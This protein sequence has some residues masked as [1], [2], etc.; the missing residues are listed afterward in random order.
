MSQT[1]IRP[2]TPTERLALIG[3]AVVVAATVVIGALA[4]SSH[5]SPNVTVAD[6]PT[7]T[8]WSDGCQVCSR[9]PEGIACSLP[10]IACVP[11][12]E[13]CLVRNDG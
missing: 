1:P 11:S 9:R 4:P 12:G 2:N 5:P 6:D 3:I 10:G 7:C 13:R 8:E